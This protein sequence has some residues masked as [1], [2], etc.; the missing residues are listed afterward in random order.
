MESEA[1]KAIAQ[2]GPAGIVLL[3]TL[4][5]VFRLLTWVLEKNA[6]REA[7]LLEF[8]KTVSPI[9]QRVCDCVGENKQILISIDKK[10]DGCE[11]RRGR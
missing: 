1:L 5:G 6:E 10:V 3:I 11:E 2:W 4:F 8:V 9:L 7:V